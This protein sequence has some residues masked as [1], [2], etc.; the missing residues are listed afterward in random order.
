MKLSKQEYVAQDYL[1]ILQDV[2]W[3]TEKVSDLMYQL[4][5]T[6]QNEGEKLS[7]Y[8]RQLDK[9]MHQ[10]LLKKGLDPRKVD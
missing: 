8:M 5:H 2:F 10:I 1:N 3:C 7:D 4:E 6:Y 9:I